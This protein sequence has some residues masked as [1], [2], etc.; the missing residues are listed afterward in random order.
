MIRAAAENTMTGEALSNTAMIVWLERTARHELITNILPFWSDL[1]D[2]AS[3]TIV[4]RVDGNGRREHGGALSTVY[5]SQ[6][7][8]AFAE[9]YA[10]IGDAAL[11]DRAGMVARQLLSHH[12]D[13]SCGGFFWSVGGGGD[14]LETDKHL[15]AQAFAI[16]ALASAA[17][18]IDD[19]H[20]GEA[21]QETF[22]LVLEKAGDQAHGGFLESFDRD[23]RRIPNKRMYIGTRW[24][25]KSTNC[26]LHLLDAFLSLSKIVPD[27]RLT[28]TIEHLVR[29]VLH[30]L[31]DGQMGLMGSLFD[32]AWKRMD[33][34]WSLGQNF[35][36][37]RLLARAAD[38]S[39]DAALSREASRT[40]NGMVDGA[41]SLGQGKD[42]GVA[43]QLNGRR[44]DPIRYW[45]VQAEAVTAAL[46]R[47]GNT[48]PRTVRFARALSQATDVWRYILAHHSDPGTGEWI[49]RVSRR[50]GPDRAAPKADVFKGAFHSTLCCLQ[51]L[52][53]GPS[54]RR[55]AA[56]SGRAGPSLS[57]SR[58]G[59]ARFASIAAICRRGQFAAAARAAKAARQADPD[60]PWALAA[61]AMICRESGR[62]ADAEIWAV[63]AIHR[64]AGCPIGHAEAGIALYAQGRIAQAHAALSRGVSA[65]LPADHPAHLVFCETLLERDGPN[66]AL[67][68]LE[69]RCWQGAD[70]QEARALQGLIRLT[71]GGSRHNDP[72][73]YPD[74]VEGLQRDC[75]LARARGIYKAVQIGRFHEAETLARRGLRLIPA[76]P[77]L[78]GATGFLYF[79]QM[80]FLEAGRHLEAATPGR[81]KDPDRIRVNK[82]LLA[83][84]V[85]DFGRVI[86]LL[87]QVAGPAGDQNL[88]RAVLADSWRHAGQLCRA[89]RLARECLDRDPHSSLAMAVLWRLDVREDGDPVEAA[90]AMLAKRPDEAPTLFFLADRLWATDPDRAVGLAR[91]GIAAQP[92]LAD[93][94]FWAERLGESVGPGWLVD[95]PLGAVGI[96]TPDR[97]IL[98][99]KE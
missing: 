12:R 63:A 39:A 14:A 68:A 15:Y 59:G 55:I 95:N 31:I 71:L 26:H 6:L 83:Y 19:H 91:R 37:A 30:R 16:N 8:W 92:L 46:R 29:L 3:G 20:L 77:D 72:A 65:D 74:A 50:F 67:K 64:D 24:A 2:P 81:A 88:I 78:L 11:A 33:D 48:G 25:P 43:L 17:R 38:A 85:H 9:S 97:S 42:G 58:D 18:I 34:V 10:L 54:L 62:Y 99:A 76:D 51:I 21:A 44:L 90:M 82:A 73:G 28:L 40:S 75:G 4:G 45:F 5:V 47:A 86:A 80:R 94:G 22:D 60:S 69:A 79:V 61:L 53:L 36:A 57:R 96:C 66:A 13:P 87:D 49:A 35:A 70:D 41:F 52:E 56:E 93:A 98:I 89:E 7:L 23:W 84:R 32:I 1:V 27:R